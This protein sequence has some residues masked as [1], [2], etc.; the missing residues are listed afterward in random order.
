MEES[1]VPTFRFHKDDFLFENRIKRLAIL[2]EYNIY[3]PVL[4]KFISPLELTQIEIIINEISERTCLNLTKITLK[5]SGFTF[6]L[7]LTNLPKE[8]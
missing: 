5:D 2:R 3:K 7:Y 8:K 4:K 6:W 1:F